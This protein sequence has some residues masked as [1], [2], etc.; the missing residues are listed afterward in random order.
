MFN[1]NVVKL[2]LF[3][4]V[5]ESKAKMETITNRDF[6]MVLMFEEVA[7]LVIIAFVILALIKSFTG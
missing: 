2:G 7:A 1:A 5:V 6:H 4:D 3:K